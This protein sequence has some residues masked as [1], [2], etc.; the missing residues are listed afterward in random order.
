MG[1]V[2]VK[3]SQGIGAALLFLFIGLAIYKFFTVIF[4]GLTRKGKRKWNQL[5]F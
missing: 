2:L 3:I 5:F 4:Y 1:F